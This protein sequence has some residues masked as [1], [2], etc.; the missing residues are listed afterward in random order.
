MRGG[1]GCA[2]LA[3]RCGGEIPG[4]CRYGGVAAAEACWTLRR[5]S[6]R[7]TTR[8]GDR[9]AGGGLSG[10]TPMNMNELD[11]RAA[12]VTGASRNIGRAIAVALGA[13]GASV[14]VH[15]HRRP[16]R[17]GGDRA[18]RPRAPA[19]GQSRRSAT[20]PIRRCRG[21]S[22]TAALAAFGRL[23]IVVANAAIRPEAA[24]DD[25]SLRGLAA[26]DGDLPRQRLPARQGRARPAAGR[27]TRAAIVTD[28]R[29]DRPY[30][31]AATARTSSPPRRP[32][33][34]SPRRWRTIS[35]PDGITVNCVAPG[36]IETQ[37]AGAEPHHH[38]SRTNALGRR[39]AAGRGRSI[40]SGCSAGPNARYITGQTIHVNGGALMV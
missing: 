19:E 5:A 27:A 39:G 6:P 18:A 4:Q 2:A 40:R 15:A 38:A 13:G 21:A 23:D 7:A 25:L 12:I 17:R 9:G 26:R 37:R 14:L 11:G 22:S 24:I 8:G 35:A 34:G 30:R 3:R 1:V 29:P 36:L 20:S 16:R 10:M 28:R 32:S 31:R 33:P